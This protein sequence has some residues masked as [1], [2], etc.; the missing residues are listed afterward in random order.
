MFFL[1]R[2]A[3]SNPSSLAYLLG[4]GG[5]GHAIAVDVHAEDV[6]WFLQQAA[7]QAV[8]IDYVIDTHIHADHVS[9]GRELAQRC[10]GDYCLHESSTPQ[11]AF[12]SLKDGQV[13]VAHKVSASA[14]A[15]IDRPD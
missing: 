4:C 6:E 1:Q 3:P 7:Q 5:K 12:T 9:G 13:S 14:I 2:A 8:K 15:S 10:G 11:F